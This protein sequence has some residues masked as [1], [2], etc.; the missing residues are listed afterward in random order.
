MA[1]LSRFEVGNQLGVLLANGL[2]EFCLLRARQLRT[3]C[4][5]EG[6]KATWKMRLKK[7]FSFTRSKPEDYEWTVY[8][9]LMCL[10]KLSLY[11]EADDFLEGIDFELRRLPL[12]YIASFFNHAADVG[13]RIGNAEMVRYFGERAVETWVKLGQR[14]QAFQFSVEY[15]IALSHLARADLNFAFMGRVLEEGLE[16]GF[17]EVVSFAV[18]E[19]L[20]A[21]YTD[22]RSLGTEMLIQSLPAIC[23][24]LEKAEE[25]PC[26]EQL[27]KTIFAIEEFVQSV[28]EIEQANPPSIH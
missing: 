4:V 21:I 26:K 11:L 10:H 16:R 25:G 13:R 19:I 22:P 9:E 2:T 23:E 15:S 28:S 14:E 7:F 12:T 6:E 18:E 27:R 5:K 3:C 17:P 1:W 8:Y 20:R 24:C